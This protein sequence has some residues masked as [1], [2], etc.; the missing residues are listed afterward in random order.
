MIRQG[1]G[2]WLA[3]RRELVTATDI[4]VLLGLSP[5]KC[6]ADL[7]DEKMGKLEAPATLRM[8]AG[9][10]LQD[11]IG[12][13][14]TE[15]TGNRLR[16][17]QGLVRHS[18]IK[19]AAASPDFRVVGEK[20]LM[21]AKRSGSRARFADGLPQDIEA[22][23]IWQEGVA[24]FPMA[25]VAVLLGDDELQVFTVPFDPA[26]FDNLV[27]VAEDFRRRLSE[28]GPFARDEA[29][30]RKDHPSDDGSTIEA[31]P[32]LTEAA[33][34]LFDVRARIEGLEQTEKALKTAIEDR[35][36]PASLLQGAGW[37]ATWK[38]SKDSTVTD[39]ESLASGFLRQLPPDE[40][41]A[42]IGLHTGVR[43]GARPFRLVA[44]KE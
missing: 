1:T 11:L 22:Q 20:R 41:E 3:A 38:R 10:A 4:P 39:W 37:H 5:Y 35:M 8:R 9:L 44:E 42:L 6:E 19:W 27:T 34:A 40:R 2:E 18:K 14:Y 25:D 17:F 36:G 16:R 15:Q 23:V 28:G 32:E 30:I 31:D 7:A 43:T 29:R 12:E 13:A 24:G 26:T 21:E 33:L